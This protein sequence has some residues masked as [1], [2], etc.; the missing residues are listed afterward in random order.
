MR[1]SIWE[2]SRNKSWG[3]IC[4][5]EMKRRW[6][7]ETQNRY[8]KHFHRITIGNKTLPNLNT[9]YIL[10][11]SSSS[12]LFSSCSSP[13]HTISVWFP[14]LF[15]TFFYIHK[16]FFFFFSIYIETNIR[17]VLS[18]NMESKYTARMIRVCAHRRFHIDNHVEWE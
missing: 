15:V 8:H 14:L 16:H 4:Y 11:S 5:D 17:K 3:E 2:I 12:K 10:I 13:F 1:I 9:R 6:N 7:R 18:Y